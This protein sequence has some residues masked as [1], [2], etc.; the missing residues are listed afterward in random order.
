MLGAI[1]R[2]PTRADFAFFAH[3][4]FEQKQVFIIDIIYFIFAETAVLALWFPL[5]ITGH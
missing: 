4:A 3:V 2:Y 1:A 5:K